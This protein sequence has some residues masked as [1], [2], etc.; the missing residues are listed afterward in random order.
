MKNE[1]PN[2]FRITLDNAV[3]CGVQTHYASDES[4]GMNGMFF[5]PHLREIFRC[6]VS[7]GEGWEHVSVSLNKRCP[8]W[9]EMCFIKGVFWGDD[10]CVI[11]YHPVKAEYVN[12]HP[13]C[14]HLWKP[15]GVEI[16]TPPKVFVGV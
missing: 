9:D 5:I 6:V 15:Q 8:T 3:R 16:P 13:F 7:D 11:Q 4:I 10:E 12:N 2:Q 1:P 14:L